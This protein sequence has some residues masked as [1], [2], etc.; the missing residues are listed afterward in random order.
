MPVSARDDDAN[1][2]SLARTLA[3]LKALG[4]IVIVTHDREL[5][6]GV[7]TKAGINTIILGGRGP[8]K[9]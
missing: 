7:G 8:R 9:A 2:S 6:E 4:Q 5:M 1:V 3:G